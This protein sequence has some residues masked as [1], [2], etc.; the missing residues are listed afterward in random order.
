MN[1]SSKTIQATEAAEKKAAGRSYRGVSMAERKS[2]RR[3]QFIAA[4]LAVIGSVGYH[5]ATVR[6]ICAEAGL[7]ERYFYESFENS[8]ALLCAVYSEQI[9]ALQ[10]Q[11]LN[12][13]ATIGPDPEKMARAALT[14]YFKANRKPQVARVTLFEI[15]GVSQRVDKL[16]RKAMDDFATL[17]VAVSKAANPAGLHT[18]GVD[19]ELLAAGLVGSVVQIAMRWSL[20]GYPQPLGAVVNSAYAIFAAVNQQVMQG[21]GKQPARLAALKKVSRPAA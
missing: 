18:P 1:K 19:Q 4:G 2:E 8:E 15:L 9:D 11:T 20:A 10:S 17:I 14:L 21:A 3:Q 13:L 6:A 7:T 16:Y 12:A 5:A